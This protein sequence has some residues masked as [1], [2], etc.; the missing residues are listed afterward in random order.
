[1]SACQHRRTAL[2]LQNDDDIYIYIYTV[3]TYIYIYIVITIWKKCSHIMTGISVT[4]V[5]FVWQG[6]LSTNCRNEVKEY[7]LRNL[8]QLCKMTH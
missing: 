7:T 8:M 4:I 5:F 2:Q 3:Y 6:Q 1:M